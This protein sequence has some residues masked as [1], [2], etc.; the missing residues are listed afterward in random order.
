[1][2]ELIVLEDNR[3]PPA[4][5]QVNTVNGR[6]S[7]QI[8]HIGD[9]TREPYLGTQSF[10][11]FTEETRKLSL[12]ALKALYEKEKKEYDKARSEAETRAMVQHLEQSIHAA[13]DEHA[14]MIAQTLYKRLTGKDFSL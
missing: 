14:R 10:H 11:P 13:P 3:D 1:M 2:T 9:R 4:R 5:I 7:L 8:D 6:V 12:D